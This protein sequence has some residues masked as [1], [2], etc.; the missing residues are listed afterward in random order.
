MNAP[1]DNWYH[2]NNIEEIDSPV[3]VIYPERVRQNIANAL[4]LIGDAS[5]L[6]PH[7]KTHKTKEVIKLLLK[8]GVSKFKCATIAEAELAAQCK[9]TDILLAYQPTGPKIKR[10]IALIQSFP[11][12]HFSCL[13]DSVDAALSISDVVLAQGLLVDVFID[14]NIGMNR[15]G[16]LPKDAVALYRFCKNLKGLRIVGLHGYDGHIN[17]SD[18]TVRKQQADEAFDLLENVKKALAADGLTKPIIVV[19]G[20]PTFP[21]HAKRN[22]VE[23]SPGTF[24][25]WDKSYGN[26]FPEMPFVP[27]ALVISRVVSILTDKLICLDLGHKSIA[28]ENPLNKRVHFLNAPGVKFISQSEEHLVVEVPDPTYKIGNVFYGVPFHVCP[29]CA[30]YEAA[31]VIE[32]G[33][34][35]GQWRMTARDRKISI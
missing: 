35:T 22:A 5:R 12:T 14:V 4:Q 30:L 19:G 11:S 17:D 23:C 10:F 16:V 15:T 27:A 32:D 33:K 34:A 20:S 13:I 21:I 24:V 6:R 2:I 8:A 18:V 26:A 7:V 9:A 28:A 31:H 25:Y 29:G 1:V 3:L